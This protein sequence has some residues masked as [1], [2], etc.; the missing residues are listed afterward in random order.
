MNVQMTACCGL[1]CTECPAYIATRKNDTE[2]L[3]ACALEW[4][5]LE[6][7]AS[8]CLCDGC[9]SDGRKNQW[10]AECGIRTCAEARGMVNCA[11]CADYACEKLEGFFGDVPEARESL[12]RIRKLL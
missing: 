6:D 4:Y 9:L 8:F 7:D 3:K 5:G 2:K 12:E 10:C 1:I 11:H